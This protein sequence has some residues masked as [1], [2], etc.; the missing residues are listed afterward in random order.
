[1]AREL[2]EF[3]DVRCV[4]ETGLALLC[5]INGSEVWIPRS[6]VD[7]SSDVLGEDDEGE[8]VI[9][10]WLAVEKGLV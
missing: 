1:M 5:A 4:A 3:Q 10:E 8:L 2:V 7:D 6:Q 9:T